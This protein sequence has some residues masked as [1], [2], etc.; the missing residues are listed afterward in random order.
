MREA[1]FA[2]TA[3]GHDAPGDSDLDTRIYQLLGRFITVVSQNL[4]DGVREIEPM[5]VRQ[6]AEGFDFSDPL[7]ALAVQFVFYG[8][9]MLLK[10][11]LPGTLRRVWRVM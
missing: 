8:Q 3:D 7:D 2:H 11:M 5:A 4:R 1:G 9:F 10:T 6:E